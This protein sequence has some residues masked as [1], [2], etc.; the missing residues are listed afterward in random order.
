VALQGDDADDVII[1]TPDRDLIRGG[2][3]NDRIRGSEMTTASLG[4]LE[5]TA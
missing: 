3:G 4:R 1:G 5:G 2:G